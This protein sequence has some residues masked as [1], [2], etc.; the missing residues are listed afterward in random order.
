M[1][2]P[3]RRASA[4]AL[5]SEGA[6]STSRRCAA[7][8]A[9]RPG[10][11]GAAEVVLD[12]AGRG[13]TTR[14]HGRDAV[15]RTGCGDRRGAHR[16][17]RHAAARAGPGRACCCR[18]RAQEG[19]ALRCLALR[20][21]AE[22]GMARE[23]G[24]A[25]RDLGR[26]DRG[27]GRGEPAHRGAGGAA[28][29]GCDAAGRRVRAPVGI[30]GTL[31][32]PRVG[33]EP[34]ARAGPGDRGHGGEPAVARP[35]GG[36]AARAAAGRVAGRGLRGAA[37]ARADGRGRAAC[38]RRSA[39]CPSCRGNCRAPRRRCCAGWAGS[40]ARGRC[41]RRAARWWAS[42][43]AQRCDR[44][45]SRRRGGACRRAPVRFGLPR[46]IGPGAACRLHAA[47]RAPRMP[48]RRSPT[49]G[50]APPFHS[51]RG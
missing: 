38:R 3:T 10:S 28:A 25:G 46:T 4:L 6:G 42:V 7:R 2:P 40:A 11:R 23:P 36:M 30:G 44:A 1:P 34:G 5:R 16:A 50:A 26:A 27:R 41:D 22:D 49:S 18:A 14:G 47:R 31:A 43:A 24:A 8:A 39:S 19:V 12:I 13:A 9:K 48:V 29:A 21:S 15:G 17:G 20:M 45:S 37:A 51:A 32:A 35:D 33:V